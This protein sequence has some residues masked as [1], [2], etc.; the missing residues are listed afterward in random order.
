M[1]EKVLKTT[2]GST[3]TLHDHLK[4]HNKS[5]K[6]EAQKPEANTS[7]SSEKKTVS[8]PTAP[9]VKRLISD[10]F[11]KSSENTLP[12]VISKMAALDGIAFRLFVTPDE[13]RRCLAARGFIVPKSAA[14][15][16]NM[17]VKFADF[18]RE[19]PWGSNYSTLWSVELRRDVR[20][21]HAC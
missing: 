3:K 11:S 4:S 18:L 21:C 15:I 20:R 12:V 19:K 17:V 7:N 8:G 16:R 9:K 13:L 10:H 14:T 2:G 6:R 5:V 1:S